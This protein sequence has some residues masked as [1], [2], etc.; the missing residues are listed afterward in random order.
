MLRIAA[1]DDDEKERL[2]IAELLGRYREEKNAP[3][4]FDVYRSGMGLLEA[5]DIF[6]ASASL[7]AILLSK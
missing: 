1:C 2:R 7:N 5:R 4:H 6:K 3:L